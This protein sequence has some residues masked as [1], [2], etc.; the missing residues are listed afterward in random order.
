MQQEKKTTGLRIA[1]TGG[2]S[3]LGRALVQ[4]EEAHE[5]QFG[6][7]VVGGTDPQRDLQPFLSIK[8]FH[9]QGFAA[10]NRA[11]GPEGAERRGGNPTRGV[12]Q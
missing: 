12:D 4:Q 10:V 7:Q 2:T 3:G 5:L 1:V 11:L 8:L 9:L 6:G